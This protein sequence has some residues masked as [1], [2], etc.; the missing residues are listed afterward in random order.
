[1]LLKQ[2]NNEYNKIMTGV[3]KRVKRA[4]TLLSLNII[5]QFFSY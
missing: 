4:K 1:M 3:L 5:D 2:K